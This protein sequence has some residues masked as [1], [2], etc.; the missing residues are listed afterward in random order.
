MT[1]ET[2]Y[3][4]SRMLGNSCRGRAQQVTTA[5]A[6]TPLPETISYTCSSSSTL[7]ELQCRQVTLAT[8]AAAAEPLHE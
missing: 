4:K 2:A 5:A 3:H 7:H 1:I 6:T 8:P